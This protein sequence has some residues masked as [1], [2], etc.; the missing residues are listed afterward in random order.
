MKLVTHTERV[1]V[2][3]GVT[4]YVLHM[5]VEK[6]CNTT[7]ATLAEGQCDEIMLNL[8]DFA[9]LQMMEPAQLQEWVNNMRRKIRIR[10]D[11]GVVK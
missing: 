6:E 5:N 7:D 4:G 1:S 10:F 11:P 2:P 9:R 8:V 3:K